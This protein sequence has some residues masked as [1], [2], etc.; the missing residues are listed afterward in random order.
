VPSWTKEHGHRQPD[1]RRYEKGSEQ[2]V[3][4]AYATN[5]F[6]SHKPMGRRT[7]LI[8]ARRTTHSSDDTQA[9]KRRQ[10]Y[11]S[12]T[13]VAASHRCVQNKL[14]GCEG[15]KWASFPKARGNAAALPGHRSRR[16]WCD[17]SLRRSGDRT[18]GERCMAPSF[19]TSA[20]PQGFFLRL[21]I[22]PFGLDLLRHRSGQGWQRVIPITD[23]PHLPARVRQW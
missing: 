19:R 15:G 16:R 18:L 11:L 10:R 20:A 8:V 1:I 6:L 4:G 9:D 13:R 3:G 5:I 22:A 7:S 12:S 14:A 21:S 2:D 17:Q 23:R